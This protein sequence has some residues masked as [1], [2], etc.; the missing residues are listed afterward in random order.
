[1]SETPNGDTWSRQI[2]FKN[3]NGIHYA[4]PEGVMIES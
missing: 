2:E 4:E 3:Q 1:M